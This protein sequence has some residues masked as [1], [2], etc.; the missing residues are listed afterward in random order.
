MPE[1]N[2][3]KEFPNEGNWARMQVCIYMLAQK[4]WV[5]KW[6]LF[7]NTVAVNP[8]GVREAVYRP[9]GMPE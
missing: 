9:W 7:L 6:N 4:A 8:T 2:S 3:Q 5:F 1:L